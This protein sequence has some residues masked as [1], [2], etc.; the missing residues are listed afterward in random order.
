[1]YDKIPFCY[2]NQKYAKV[3]AKKFGRLSNFLAEHFGNIETNINQT[4]LKLN[5]KQFLILIFINAIM[6]SFFSFLFLFI[7]LW[8]TE[9]RTGLEL[10]SFSFS[11]GIAIG[12]LLF[13]VS[14]R[15]PS[16]IA[17]KK[18]QDIE[19]N[20]VFAL[21]DILLNLNAGVPIHKAFISIANSNYGALSEEFAKVGRKIQTGT[22]IDVAI[23]KMA[24]SIKS[25]FLKRAL[26]QVVNV[27]RSGSSLKDA[28]K[29]IIVDILNEQKSK[30]KDYAGE[31]NMWSLVYMIFAVAVPTI[32]TTLLLIMSS[33]GAVSVGQ[34]HLMIF[35]GVCVVVQWIVI[36]LIQS[37]RPVVEI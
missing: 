20:L 22:A 34:S 12:F 23:E 5:V 26:W 2:I 31:L 21:K 6:I 13:I 14:L 25:D 36:G 30:I 18:A 28:L 29:S 10:F 8:V 27:L 9:T 19:K 17:G 35:G 24:L 37:R 11:L 33:F 32:G 3:L 15:S 7:L 4:D 1:M 16:M